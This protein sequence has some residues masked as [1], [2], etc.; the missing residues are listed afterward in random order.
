MIAAPQALEIKKCVCGHDMMAKDDLAK[1][2]YFYNGHR[3]FVRFCQDCLHEGKKCDSPVAVPEVVTVSRKEGGEPGKEEEDHGSVGSTGSLQKTAKKGL[4][5]SIRSRLLPY[6]NGE[7]ATYRDFKRIAKEIGCVPATVYY[8]W[9]ALLKKKGHERAETGNVKE[10]VSDPANRTKQPEKKILDDLDETRSKL[11]KAWDDNKQ[12]QDQV[13]ILD[14]QL[15]DMAREAADLGTRL[16]A[17]EEN[18]HNGHAA[19]GSLRSRIEIAVYE[20]YYD[21]QRKLITESIREEIYHAAKGRT[22]VMECR[23]LPGDRRRIMVEI[24]G[25]EVAV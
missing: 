12:L 6:A 17:M 20:G 11:Q 14:S 24:S 7:E 5:E 4:T 13:H 2:T 1:H 10:P 15:K 18:Q 9:N 8:H 3:F 22:I 16:H 25:G 23:Q 19:E 21:A